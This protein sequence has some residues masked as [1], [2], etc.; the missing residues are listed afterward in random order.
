M[1]LR[2]RDMTKIIDEVG[3]PENFK[4][5]LE[6]LL[7]NLAE[8]VTKLAERY[9]RSLR[10]LLKLWDELLEEKERWKKIDRAIDIIEG[11]WKRREG[12]IYDKISEDIERLLKKYNYEL[13]FYDILLFLVEDRITPYLVEEIY[14]VCSIRVDGKDVVITADYYRDYDEYENTRRLELRRIIIGET[15]FGE[16]E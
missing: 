5:R 8:R 6:G 10:E 9:S 11:E 14:E 16:L 12:E 7:E 3:L 13:V 1:L 4:E 15:E 2:V